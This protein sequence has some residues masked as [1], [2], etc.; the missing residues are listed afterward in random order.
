MP[1]EHPELE[2]PTWKLQAIMSDIKFIEFS[3]RHLLDAFPNY[4]NSEI[5]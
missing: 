3:I 4:D 2:F 1:F 5:N